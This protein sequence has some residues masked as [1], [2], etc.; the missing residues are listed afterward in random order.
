MSTQASPPPALEPLSTSLKSDASADDSSLLHSQSSPTLED[1]SYSSDSSSAE[2]DELKRLQESNEFSP[3]KSDDPS[4]HSTM[5]NSCANTGGTS[6]FMQT[7]REDDTTLRAEEDEGEESGDYE[8]I[9]EGSTRY[10]EAYTMN[11]NS[12]ADDAGALESDGE[13]IDLEDLPETVTVLKSKDGSRTVYLVGTSH[14]SKISHRDVR[15][16]SPVDAI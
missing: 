7:A 1:I 4:P 15:R 11:F 5:Y 16:V 12:I 13:L 3:I 2:M 10:K 8:E 14:F 6:E 9:M